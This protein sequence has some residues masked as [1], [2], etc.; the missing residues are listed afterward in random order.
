MSAGE[1][2]GGPS[3]SSNYDDV[4]VEYARRFRPSSS[5]HGGP[6]SYG[7][8]SSPS[9]EGPSSSYANS[10]SYGRPSF[11]TYEDDIAFEYARRSQAPSPPSQ[12]FD[13]YPSIRSRTP[14]PSARSASYAGYDSNSY[15]N[16]DRDRTPST[17]RYSSTYGNRTSASSRGAF[18]IYED[19]D[20]DLEDRRRF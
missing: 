8:S 13:S 7:R 1:S 10:S 14:T 19:P 4:D 9:Y 2:Y 15:G 16:F 6:S 20:S 18:A 12:D 3:S 5:S 11:P 17:T